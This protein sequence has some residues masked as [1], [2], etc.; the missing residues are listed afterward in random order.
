MNAVKGLRAV[1][2]YSCAFLEG[3]FGYSTSRD[4]DLVEEFGTNADG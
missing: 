4:N 1:A 3:I 2:D